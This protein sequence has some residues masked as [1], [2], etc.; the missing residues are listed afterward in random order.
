MYRSLLFQLLQEIPEF[1]HTLDSIDAASSKWNLEIL[2]DRFRFAVENLKQQH[3]VCFVDA[4][5]E[6]PEDQIRDM[7]RFFESFGELALLKHIGFHVC[8]FSRHY[9]HI[10]IRKGLHL[11][12][13]NLAG[14]DT[15]LA[16]YLSSELRIE[17]GKHFRELKEEIL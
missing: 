2:K 12:L 16:N 1:Q 5:D 10:T 3:L 7:I 6:C 9:P 17:D 4:L 13:E 15:D 8:F 14:H 11:V